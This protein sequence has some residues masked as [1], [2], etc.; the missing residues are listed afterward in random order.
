MKKRIKRTQKLIGWY[1]TSGKNNNRFYVPVD[2]EM[3]MTHRI[4]EI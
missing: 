4:L 2:I 3:E 1:E